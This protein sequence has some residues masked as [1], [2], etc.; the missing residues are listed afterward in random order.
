M[1][2]PNELVDCILENLY[3]DTPTLL[4]C[5][6]VGKAWVRPSQRGIFRA[7]ILEFPLP[8]PYASD[9][10]YSV[11]NDYVNTCEHFVALFDR[12]AKPH[13]ASY[14]QS[15]ELRRFC[16]PEQDALHAV[17][18]KVIQRLTDVK[19]LSLFRVNWDSYT[20][21]PLLKETL[22][23]VFKAPSLNEVSSVQSCPFP[24]LAYLLSHAA[25][26][27]VLNVDEGWVS[28]DSDS[29]D[30]DDENRLVGPLIV[31]TGVNP[32]HSILLDELRIGNSGL[33]YLFISWLRQDSCPFLA[34]NL[35]S[36]E[37]HWRINRDVLQYLGSNL[38]EL[39]CSLSSG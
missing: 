23:E 32:P 7:I 9:A 10:E 11:V 13:L 17:T 39:S 2:F 34:Q 3:L 20:L 21:S 25:H 4:N 18:A 28:G 36:L 1:L 12:D 35:Q 16:E 6:L 30:D 24:E 8:A 33:I 26:L 31:D 27:K 38:K 14:V 19:K 37:I 22:A 5:A 29:E 15:L